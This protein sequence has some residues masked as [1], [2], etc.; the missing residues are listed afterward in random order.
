VVVYETPREFPARGQWDMR[1]VIFNE[2]GRPLDAPNL[3]LAVHAPYKNNPGVSMD[4]GSHTPILVPTRL[5]PG[6]SS[7]IDFTVATMDTPRAY[8]A[9]GIVSLLPGE[10]AVTETVTITSR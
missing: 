6:Q 10:A 1:F 5:G 7:T 3:A 9:Q 4:V 2:S 8:L